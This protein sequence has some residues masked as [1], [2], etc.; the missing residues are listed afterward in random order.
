VFVKADLPHSRDDFEARVPIVHFS[1]FDDTP[2]A[3]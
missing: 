1:L 3:D 2:A